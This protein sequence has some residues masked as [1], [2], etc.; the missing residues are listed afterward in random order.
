M[1]NQKNRAAVLMLKFE[2]WQLITD[3][4]LRPSCLMVDLTGNLTRLWLKLDIT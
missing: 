2:P 1:L 3:F 4:G